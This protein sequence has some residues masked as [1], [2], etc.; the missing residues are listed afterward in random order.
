M[1]DQLQKLYFYFRALTFLLTTFRSR[2]HKPKES[3]QTVHRNLFNVRIGA[4]EYE[5]EQIA[6]IFEILRFLPTETS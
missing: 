1:I 3:I 6:R 2:N 4:H 5:F